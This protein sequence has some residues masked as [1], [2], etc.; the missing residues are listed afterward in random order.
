M[1]AEPLSDDALLARLV[2][3]DTTSHKS[4][5]EIADF[6]CDYVDRPGVRITRHPTAD[7]AKL[8]LIVAAGPEEKGRGLVLSGHMDVVPAESEG[9]NSDP[10]TLT[11]SNEFY[12]ARGAADM[13][14]FLAL[15]INRLA[16]ADIPR[17]EHQLALLFTHDEE[18]GTLGARRLMDDPDVLP[19]LPSATIIGEPTSLRV[20]R[21]HKGHLRL[22][23]SFTGVPAHS[24]FPH[25]GVNAIEAAGRAIV[26]LTELRQA[27]ER[28]RPPNAEHFAEVPYVTLNI[29]RVAGGKATNVVPADCVLELGI[30]L[31][32]GMSA[33]E[34]TERVRAVVHEAASRVPYELVVLGDTPPMITA[35][36]APILR[37]LGGELE[38]TEYGSASFGTD[39]GW[40]SRLG[41]DCVIWGPGAIEV[42]HKPNEWL[43]IAEFV[44]AG[45]L[46]TRLVYRACVAGP[47]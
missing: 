33:D 44:R 10:F 27:L 30:R 29:A 38:Q 12:V 6:I 18:T 37:L 24:G 8:N 5:R 47:S 4:N 11:R 46:L 45:E 7:G 26:A 2:D 25:L 43:P 19:P 39:G 14:G 40:F 13:K 1:T 9:W 20:L 21:M 36:N 15:A 32:P 17:L 35:E 16:S 23:L 41:L 3:F 22:Q 28:E 34:M 42:A 31:L